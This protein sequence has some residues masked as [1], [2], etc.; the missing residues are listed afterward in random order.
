MRGDLRKAINLLLLLGPG[1]IIGLAVVCAAGHAR[2]WR[3]QSRQKQ[4]EYSGL[5]S[6]K[7]GRSTTMKLS[8]TV[9]QL[10]HQA[11]QQ[12]QLDAFRN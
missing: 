11:L 6:R 1:F 12:H 9:C 10:Y 5:R 8:A 2:D 4:K 3:R 7:T